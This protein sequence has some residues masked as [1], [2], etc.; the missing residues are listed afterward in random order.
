MVNTY[1]QTEID[2]RYK[3]AWIIPYLSVQ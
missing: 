2:C 3:P 1:E